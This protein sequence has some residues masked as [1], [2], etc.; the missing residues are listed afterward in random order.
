MTDP[1]DTQ[2]DVS[3]TAAQEPAGGSAEAAESAPYDYRDLSQPAPLN[4]DLKQ[5][6]YQ[7][8][9]EVHYDFR[10]TRSELDLIGNALSGA[11]AA[12]WI[13]SP[14]DS[15]D[16]DLQTAYR[17]LQF[18]KKLNSAL[19]GPQRMGCICEELLPFAGGDIYMDAAYR[20][21]THEMGEVITIAQF[22][23]E[24]RT[25]CFRL[26][27]PVRYPN[28]RS[29]Q[30]CLGDKVPLESILSIEEVSA[31]TET[32]KENFAKAIREAWVSHY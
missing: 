26:F 2:K 11:I 28:A 21:K 5:N 4:M 16:E 15:I 1:I 20:I 10:F 13:F 8:A 7:P 24:E 32:E 31:L 12:S 14:D 3:T 25:V 19:A 27:D 9:E 22:D 18:L 23:Y 17:N 6:D 30:N 29:L